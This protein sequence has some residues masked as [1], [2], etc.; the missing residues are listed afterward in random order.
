M[1]FPVGLARVI[2]RPG[3]FAVAGVVT[4]LSALL[5]ACSGQSAKTYVRLLAAAPLPPQATKV[6]DE[7]SN[8]DF[9]VG[10]KARLVY[11]VPTPVDKTCPQLIARYTAAGYS[12]TD[13]KGY[14]PDDRPIDDAA[15][16]C[17]GAIAA[18]IPPISVSFNAYEP[19]ATKHS[20]EHGFGVTVIAPR[21]G[22]PDPKGCRIVLGNL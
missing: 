10:A 6:A 20:S 3:R 12:V 2:H 9:E 7:Q 13:S 11:S 19:G 15:T 17:A 4:A 14:L 8:G 1:P 16:Y 21:A 18:S 22:D 5:A